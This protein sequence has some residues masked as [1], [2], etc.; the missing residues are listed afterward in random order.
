MKRVIV[1]VQDN[2]LIQI[3]MKVC[4]TLR[5]IG[6]PTIAQELMTKI[7]SLHHIDDVMEVI[8]YYAIIRSTPSSGFSGFQAYWS[9]FTNKPSTFKKQKP[10]DDSGF[11][12]DFFG[13]DDEIEDGE[14]DDKPEKS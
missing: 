9:K 6:Q 10:I 14:D 12:E 7:T 5:K 13:D 8:D 11:F 2:S 3:I 1:R 4:D